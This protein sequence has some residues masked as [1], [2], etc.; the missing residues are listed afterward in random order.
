MAV[1]AAIHESAHERRHPCALPGAHLAVEDVLLGKAMA[2]GSR[3]ARED[4]RHARNHCCPLVYLELIAVMSDSGPNLVRN[5]PR[6]PSIIAQVVVLDDS[7]TTLTH[8][9]SCVAIVADAVAT[10][11]GLGA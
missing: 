4:D 1:V 7:P 6:P 3:A 10:Q 5:V 8:I 2:I 11:R 9:H